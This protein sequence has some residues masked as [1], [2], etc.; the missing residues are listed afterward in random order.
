MVAMTRIVSSMSTASNVVALLR[1]LSERARDDRGKGLSDAV[2]V[3][4]DL[5]RVVTSG[6]ETDIRTLQSAVAAL[7]EQLDTSEVNDQPAKAL[8]SSNSHA[9]LAGAMWAINEMMSAQLGTIEST[10]VAH[11]GTTR[12]SQVEE[13]ALV[14]LR[15]GRAVT[16]GEILESVG[17]RNLN[18]RADEVSKALSSLLSQGLVVQA[19]PEDSGADRRRKYFMLAER[20]AEHR[21]SQPL[22]R[23]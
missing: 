12:R 17:G 9:Y 4:G 15:E 13:V 3:V 5:S 19:G 22:R 23:H 6:A 11:G 21:D 20:A 8:D 16:P 1:A 10:R 2:G 14:A 7:R 18:L